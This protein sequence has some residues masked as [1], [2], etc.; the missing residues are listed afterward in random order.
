MDEMVSFNL[1]DV[2]FFL[3]KWDIIVYV[4]EKNCEEYFEKIK[5]VIC[6]FWKEVDDLYIF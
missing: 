2:I 3:N 6:K 4:E 5:K 1:N